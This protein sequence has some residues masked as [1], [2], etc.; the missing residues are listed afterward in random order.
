MQAVAP[1][2]LFALVLGT[3]PCDI[4]TS[5]T[6]AEDAGTDAP[7]QPADAG[8]PCDTLAARYVQTAIDLNYCSVAGDCWAYAADCAITTHAGAPSCYLVLN[9]GADRTQFADMSLAW[10]QL[11]CP[12]DDEC[13]TCGAAPALDCLSGVCVIVQ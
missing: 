7:A 6:P 4:S 13:G 11:R 10:Q 12:T 8:D 1:L 5:P 9:Q 3:G 2:A